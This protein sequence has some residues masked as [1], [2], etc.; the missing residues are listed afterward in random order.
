VVIIDA[1]DQL[2][3][4]AANAL[5]KILEEPPA[6]AILFLICHRPGALLPTIRSRCRL[7]K[8]STPDDNAFAKILGQI[9][10]SIET[11]EYAALYALAQGSPGHAITLLRAR[12][13]GGCIG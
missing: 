1:V 5:L 6:K 9:A 2:N 8:L 4:Q 10:P 13:H 3:T 11:H 12:H 7:M